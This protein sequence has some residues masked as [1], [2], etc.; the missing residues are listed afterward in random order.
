MKR[1][2]RRTAAAAKP[3]RSP[4]T[5]PPRASDQIAAFKARGDD[6]VANLG[7]GRIGFR[8]LA[9]RDDDGRMANA[10]LVE[11]FFQR[12][13]MDRG[14]IGVGHDGAGRA[15]REALDIVAGPGDEARAN[16]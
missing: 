5:P 9:R 13:K 8:R 7:K 1:M 14:D 2:P 3:A 11:R 4:T 15:G 12:R 6:P 10:R 16:Q